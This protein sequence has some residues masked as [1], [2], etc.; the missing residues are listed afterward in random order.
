LAAVH[1]IVERGR[2]AV[3]DTGTQHSVTTILQALDA[4]GIDPAAVDYVLLTHVH[5]DHAGAAGALMRALPAARLVVHPRGAR[6]MI[7]PAKLVAGATAVYGEA[8][9]RALYGEIVPVPAERVQEADDGQV[10]ELHGRP[11]ICYDAP[12]HARHHLVF[13]DP[14]S[15]GVF[16]GDA[17]GLSYREFDV[18]GRAF[19]FPTTTPVQFDPAAM[20]ATIDR[21]LALK[22]RAAY[23][24]HFGRV[25]ELPRLA[26]ELHALIDAHVALAES[27]REAGA[28]RHIRL[29]EGLRALLT[30]RLRAHGCRLS[31]ERIEALLAHD[32]ELNAQGLEVWLDQAG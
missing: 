28:A 25:T 31:A 26:A 7:D 10:V 29:V 27:L 9:F 2:A 30:E 14:A 17:F 16:T 4:L 12:G 23:L 20:H 1:L 15:G 21:I 11:L 32:I 13:H 5:L 19:V 22:P 6:H 24:T 18:D 3:I 8:R